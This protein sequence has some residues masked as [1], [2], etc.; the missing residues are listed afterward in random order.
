MSRNYYETL[1]LS[2]GCTNEEIANAYSR[3]ALKFHPKNSSQNESAVF[4]YQLHQIAEAY[5]V[6]S[7]RKLFFNLSL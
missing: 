3:L 5:E 2:R 6:L 1:E 7:D 4:N